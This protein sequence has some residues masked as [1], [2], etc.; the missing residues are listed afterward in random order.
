[1]LDAGTLS[2]FQVVIALLAGNI[3][4]AP[5]CALRHQMPYYMGIFTPGLGICL[6][7]VSQGVR[8]GSL[9]FVGLI[10]V[11]AMN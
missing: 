1:M 9:I 2:V 7:L 4:A 6:M 5:V 8:I 11:L 10:Y 3:I